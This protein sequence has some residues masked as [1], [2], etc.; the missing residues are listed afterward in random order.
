[1][2][3]VVLE[4]TAFTRCV[5]APAPASIHSLA[6]RWDSGAAVHAIAI[7]TQ[8]IFAAGSMT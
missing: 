7:A 4:S 5:P 8:C 2:A 1:M 3:G 6:D